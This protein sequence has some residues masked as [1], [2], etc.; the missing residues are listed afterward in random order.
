LTS[1]LLIA[2]SLLGA[3]GAQPAG[4]MV[5]I[6]SVDGEK[7]L[8]I[9]IADERMPEP[10][11]SPKWEWI[12]EW[13][14]GCFGRKPG[15]QAFALK[16][17]VFS[18]MKKAENDPGESVAR[19]AMRLWDYNL[20][21]LRFEH[22]P[23][24]NNGNIQF[25]LC[26]GG[27][28]GGEQLFDT[29]KQTGSNQVN[30]IYIYAIQ[31]FTDPVEM[32]REVAHEYGHATLPPIGGFKQPEDWAQGHL[33]E[34]LY[35]KW[36]HADLASGRIH[37]VDAMGATADKI[38]AWVK[39][40]V[41]P[42]VEQAAVR[43][44]DVTLLGKTGPEAMNAY[45]GLAMYA[46]AMLP[47]SAFARSIKLTGST[48]AFD[49][50]KAIVAAAAEVENL[51]LNVPESLRKRPIWIPLGKGKLKGQVNMVKQSGDWAQVT[52]PA[53]AITITNPP[54]RQ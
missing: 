1:A 51:V 50:P 9:Q 21:K 43:G 14:I 17:Q 7:R 28:A 45:L 29:D 52:T 23:S 25:Y 34:R 27:K 37:P 5:E 46:E 30:T 15:D 20:L 4:R 13:P 33:G 35:L 53:G 3:Q 24:V 11:I 38:G 36:L 47:I 16:F 10:K 41:D 8:M 26:F 31:T 49:Y 32:A 54:P 44:P 19:F 12:F 6:T 48:A 39:R 42:L 40:N 22:N 2:V 18:Q